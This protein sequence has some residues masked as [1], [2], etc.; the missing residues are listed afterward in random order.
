MIKLFSIEI[1]EKSNYH[2][3]VNVSNI[4]SLKL[5]FKLLQ[6][7]TDYTE[8]PVEKELTYSVIGQVNE[9]MIEL[10]SEEVVE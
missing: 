9:Q 5:A 1:R 6:D 8:L 7:I 3:L 4:P 2:V 10:S